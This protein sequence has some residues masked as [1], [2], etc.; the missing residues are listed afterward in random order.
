MT[1]FKGPLNTEGTIAAA[2]AGVR[3]LGF[4]E[5][6]QS[7]ASEAGTKTLTSAVKKLN[8][9]SHLL[10]GEFPDEILAAAQRLGSQLAFLS[11][12]HL[13]LKKRHLFDQLLFTAHPEPDSSSHLLLHDYEDLVD[14]EAKIDALPSGSSIAAHAFGGSRAVPPPSLRKV[15]ARRARAW[16]R[17]ARDAKSRWPESDFYLELVQ[18][19][20]RARRPWATEGL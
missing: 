4:D 11:H 1:T 3:G 2:L 5:A 13:Q 7:A 15:C 20:R 8:P 10:S 18:E 9:K 14:L 19:A 12:T 16:I 17:Y 6:V